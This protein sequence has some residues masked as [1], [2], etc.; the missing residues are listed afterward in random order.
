LAENQGAVG[1]TVL[2]DFSS[3]ELASFPDAAVSAART[4]SEAA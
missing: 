1:E 4:S 3:E 2:S